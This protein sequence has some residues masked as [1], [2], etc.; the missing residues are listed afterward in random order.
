M[1]SVQPAIRASRSEPAHLA[2]RS[3]PAK[4]MALS[5]M[6]KNPASANWASEDLTE[7]GKIE[8][9]AIWEPLRAH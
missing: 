4:A 9:R 5:E 6:Q 8:R 1:T 2:E 7:K 3:L